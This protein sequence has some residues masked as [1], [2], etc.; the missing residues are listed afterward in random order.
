MDQIPDPTS[1]TTW[2]SALV[3]VVL[4]VLVLGL[5]SVLAYL[6]TK[7]TKALG[8]TLTETNGGS[9]VKDS[10]N[11]IEAGV[12]EHTAALADLTGRIETLETSPVDSEGDS[13]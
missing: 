2:P 10:L 8:R 7:Q 11:R 4:L 5:P 1:V 6:G 9:S 13:A 3:T 12:A